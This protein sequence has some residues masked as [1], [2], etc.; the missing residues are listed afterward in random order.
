MPRKNRRPDE[1][2]LWSRFCSG[3]DKKFHMVSTFQHRNTFVDLVVHLPGP[4]TLSGE[5]YEKSVSPK[6]TTLSSGLAALYPILL[7]GCRSRLWTAF[8]MGILRLVL[9]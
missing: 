9:R 8:R 5:F 7:H 2:S 4:I 6:V 1:K 3:T